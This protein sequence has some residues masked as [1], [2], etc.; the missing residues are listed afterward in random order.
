MAG[1]PRADRIRI[2]Q[3]KEIMTDDEI[4]AETWRISSLTLSLTGLDE[5]LM[6][7]AKRRLVKNTHL[8]GVCGVFCQLQNRASRIDGKHWACETCRYYKSIRDTTFFAGSH[9][10]TKQIM[11]LV[12]C[13]CQD[14]PQNVTAH[15]VD[16][17]GY[18]T[19]VDWCNFCREECGN[20]LVRNLTRLGGFDMN[21]EPTIVEIDETKYFHRKYHRG[22]WTEGHWVFGGVERMSG[23][24][25]MTLVPDRSAAT[26]ETIILQHLL[27]GTHII[28][29]GWRAYRNLDHIGNG[30]Y[31]HS[32]VIHERNFVDP[33]DEEVHTQ[34]IESLWMHAKRK[35]R[36]QFGTSRQLFPSYLQEFQYRKLVDAGSLFSHFITVLAEN[37]RV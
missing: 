34:N 28:S 16:I 10:S 24:C 32:V 12:Y 20:Y 7:L 5:C 14:L 19:I 11:L 30:I 21:G 1:R 4:Q 9:L 25:F 2:V 15:E 8:C 13:W 18:H 23:R 17:N 33:D 35:L 22:L 6:W 36:R 26:L 29:D 27:P 3:E 37:Y 31:Q